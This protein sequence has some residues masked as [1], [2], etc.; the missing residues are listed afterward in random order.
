MKHIFIT[1]LFAAVFILISGCSKE[2]D[3]PPLSLERSYLT[4]RLFSSL[5]KDD[6]NSAYEQAEKLQKL[7]P[8]NEYLNI[9]AE[10]QIAN[11]YLIAAQKELD[12]GNDL[13]AL[14]ILERGISK[15]PV[16]RPL[17]Q[18]HKNLK[19]LLE[20]DLALKNNKLNAIPNDLDS[21]PVHGPQLV[22]KM[23][24]KNIPMAEKD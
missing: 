22:K 13:A 11:T 8:D 18:Q 6:R 3:T 7:F 10:N 2:Q 4:L 20:I 5:E 15:Y 14:K 1:T 19:L 21:V 23:Q 9:V 16:N 12:N 24:S 17:Q